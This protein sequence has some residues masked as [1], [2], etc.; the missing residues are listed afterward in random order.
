MRLVRRLGW[1]AHGGGVVRGGE[2]GVSVEVLVMNGRLR[3]RR[4]G[5]CGGAMRAGMVRLG[6]GARGGGLHFGRGGGRLAGRGGSDARAGRAQRVLKGAA[7]GG[8]TDGGG[9]VAHGRARC[10]AAERARLVARCGARRVR[11]GWR[12]ASNGAPLR[13]G[14]RRRVPAGHKISQKSAPAVARRVAAWP[15]GAVSSERAIRARCKSRARR[16]GALLVVGDV[17]EG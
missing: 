12:S 6:V 4:D 7:D 17:R 10:A 9:C 11:V 1:R 8:R 2:W 16:S 13:A 5:V 3:R 14:N 15:P